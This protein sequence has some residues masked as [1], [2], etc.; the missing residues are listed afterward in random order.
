[1][2]RKCHNHTLQTKPRHREEETQS[3]NSRLT[4]KDNKRIATRPLFP[5][6]V[7]AKLET[8]QSTAQQNE[9]K[10]PRNNG[11][12]NKNESPTTEPPPK[13]A[14]QPKPLGALINLTG[15]I[16]TLQSAVVKTKLKIRLACVEIS[17]H[18]YC[19]ITGRHSNQL[20][21]CDET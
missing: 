15:Q 10:P 19:T 2:T 11:C 14:R 5:S 4:S 18:I 13:N 7:I 21:Y 3:S 1:M 6:E 16:F 17:K 8:T 12:N 9:D 20:K